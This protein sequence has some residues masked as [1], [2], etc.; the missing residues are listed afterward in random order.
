MLAGA[1]RSEIDVLYLLGADEIDMNRLGKAFVIYQGSHGD[2]GA[3]RA[4]V[5]LPGA[6]YTEKSATYVSTEGRVQMTSKAAFP[7]GEAKEDWA[8]VR[9]LSAQA[10][11]TLPYDSLPALRAA[12]YKVAP[13][14]AGLDVAAPAGIQGVEALAARAGRAR[15][16]SIRLAGARLLPDQS[17]RARLRR[18]WPSWRRC[19]RL[20]AKGRRSNAWLAPGPGRRSG[21][22]PCGRCW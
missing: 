13:A 10:G 17:D 5:I 18:A 19:A 6:A 2:A 20:R 8:I 9:A 21:R 4:D 12:M 15:L 16:R 7:P 11:Q 14:L 22:A 1:A 3:H